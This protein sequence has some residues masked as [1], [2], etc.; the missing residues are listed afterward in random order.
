MKKTTMSD[1]ARIAGVSKA[2][3]SM[4]L[5]KKDENIS[6]ETKNRIL[7][8]AKEMNYIP[9]SVARSLSTKR[10]STIGI[11]V[12]DITNPYFSEVSRAIEDS[13]NNY[14]Y[15]VILCNSDNETEKEEKYVELLISKL[16]DGVIF[17]VGGH[18]TKGIE[19]LK[20]NNVPFVLLDRHVEGFENLYG[21][22]CE[23]QLGVAQGVEYLY[24]SGKRKIVF[25]KGPG[26][27]EIAKQRLYGYKSTMKKYGIFNESFV[28]ESDFTMQGGKNV[29]EK[30]L[31]EI[32][33]IDAIFYSNDA[34]AVGG[35]KVLLRRGYKVPEDI[36][37]MGFDNIQIS[38][39]VEPELTTIG[40]PI[41]EM[42]RESCRLLIDVINNVDVEK[43]EIYFKPQ[44]IKRGTA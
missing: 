21:V 40:Q 37:I 5:N 44:I 16:V 12:P 23:N 10:S 7:S 24:E 20:G 22:Y 11:I 19:L 8:I 4:V 43:K 3:V 32:E 39:F 9:N 42:G 34:M 38:E 15:N 27:I 36:S 33:N 17:A 18:N 2:T 26:D 25:V 13:A 31:S 41:Y 35:M 28:F 29:T 6:E 14:G 30:I 1:I